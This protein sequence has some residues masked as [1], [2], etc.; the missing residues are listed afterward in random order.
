VI[1]QIRPSTT[2]LRFRK[3]RLRLAVRYRPKGN[4]NLRWL[5]HFHPPPGAP[6]HGRLRARQRQHEPPNQ[7]GEGETARPGS[8][9]IW[10]DAQVARPAALSTA[11]KD[12]GAFWFLT[13][14]KLPTAIEAF[15]IGA[16]TFVHR[17]RQARQPDDRVHRSCLR[18]DLGRSTRPITIGGESTARRSYDESGFCKIRP[19]PRLGQPRAH[20]RVGAGNEKTTRAV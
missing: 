17:C 19:P 3:R 14:V 16:A 18:P 6:R 20:A 8:R 9:R 13:R 11:P 5:Q 2:R 10:W 15:P 12:S 1:A 7:S 4:A